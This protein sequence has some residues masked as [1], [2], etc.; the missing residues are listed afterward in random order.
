MDGRVWPGGF[1]D[2]EEPC[3]DVL[4]YYTTLTPTGRSLLSPEMETSSE[5]LITSVITFLFIIYSFIYPRD[6][7]ITAS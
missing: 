4:G 7:Y 2:N 6:M 1:H 3:C 5:T